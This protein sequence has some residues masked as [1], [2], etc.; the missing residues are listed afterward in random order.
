MESY[1]GDRLLAGLNEAQRE[2]VTYGDGPILILAGAGSGKTRTITHRIAHL[3]QAR[4]VKPWEI[5]AVTFTNKA[6]NE[7]G[8]RVNSLLGTTKRLPYLGTFHSVCLRILRLH[9]ELLGYK[10]GFVIYDEKDQSSL[11]EKLLP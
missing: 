9:S 3:I 2:A 11:V 7:M 1:N 6:A 10:S 4:G 8:E 5:L